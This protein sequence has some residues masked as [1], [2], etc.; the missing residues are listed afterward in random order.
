VRMS[1]ECDS[2][3][4]VSLIQSALPS[5]SSSLSG[6][7]TSPDDPP[8]KRRRKPD[9]SSIIRMVGLS[10]PSFDV[11]ESI[12][13]ESHPCT[14]LTPDDDM[15]VSL[16]DADTVISSSHSPMDNSISMSPLPLDW[17]KN[18]DSS[19][20]LACPTPKCDGSGHQTGL[21]THHRS[22]SGCPRRP[23]KGTIQRLSLASDSI[24]R[25]TT[26][27]CNG[28]GHVNNSRTSH[29]SLSGCPIAHQEKQA[30]K[31]ARVV[32]RLMTSSNTPISCDSLVTSG[33]KI[34]GEEVPLD[35]S[36]GSLP[37]HPFNTIPLSSIVPP[38]QLIFDAIQSMSTGCSSDGKN[39]SVI[40]SP[41]PLPLPLLF[42]NQLQLTQLLL[43]QLSGMDGLI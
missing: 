35:L 42:P 21:Y 27:G 4:L 23:D 38:S 10:C 40:V 31:N 22:L 32:N 11:S 8:T 36:I 13:S 7:S 2:V 28:K 3:S 34:E 14:V 39:E 16:E 29:R 24:L 33:S 1:S 6:R 30:R 41:P 15:G 12:E 17:P 25:C 5:S 19:G 37:I 9:A 18:R 26:L 20:K 43:S